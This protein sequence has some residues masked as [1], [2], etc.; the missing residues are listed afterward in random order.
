MDVFKYVPLTFSLRMNEPSFYSDLQNF[1]R[2]FMALSKKVH[3]DTIKPIDTFKDSLG[4]IH[5]VFFNFEL[6]IQQPSGIYPQNS[7]FTNI[8]A[9]SVNIT[10]MFDADKH[11]WILKPTLLSR[12]R[13][14]ELFTGLDELNRYLQMYSSGYDAKDFKHMKYSHKIEKSPSLVIS[15]AKKDSI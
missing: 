8:K 14:L 2:T 7:K 15:K 3:P 13:G 11:L 10:P 12:G 5:D 6:D 1:A 9:S 4:N